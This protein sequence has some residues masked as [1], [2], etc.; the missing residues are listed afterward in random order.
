MHIVMGGLLVILG[1]GLWLAAGLV[2]VLRMAP[3]A[4]ARRPRVQPT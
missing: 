2:P 3:Q 1:I 4:T